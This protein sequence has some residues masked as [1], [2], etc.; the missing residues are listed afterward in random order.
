MLLL[1]EKMENETFSGDHQKS[2]KTATSQF[3]VNLQ[4]FPGLKV[5]KNDLV[6]KEI[7]NH[8]KGNP[9]RK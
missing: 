8:M 5:L 3:L 9:S 1:I 2:D 7:R 6:E 4:Y